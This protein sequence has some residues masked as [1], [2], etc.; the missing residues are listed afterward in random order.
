MRF[1]ILIVVNQRISSISCIAKK[2][3]DLSDDFKFSNTLLVASQKSLKTP[4]IR[5]ISNFAVFAEIYSCVLN[6]SVIR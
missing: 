6:L 2:S 1:C 4:E 5:I 3:F